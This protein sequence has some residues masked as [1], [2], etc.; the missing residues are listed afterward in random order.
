MKNLLVF[1]IFSVC[2]SFTYG[3]TVQ[4]ERKV[5]QLIT[6]Q[7]FYLNGGAKATL[8]VGGTSRQSFNIVLPLNTVEWYFSISTSKN[9]GGS[10]AIGLLAQLTRLYDPTG[11]L[12]I[13]TNSILIPSGDGVCNIYLM[14]KV[15]SDKFM[16][17]ADL[18]G[19][20]LEIRES[21]SRNNFQDGT[22]QIKDILA[23]SWYLGFKNP[24]TT[25]GISITVEVVAIVEE[26]KKVE[27]TETE[28]T[29]STYASLGWNSFVKGEY[30]KSFELCNQAVKLNPNLG[31]AHNNIGLIYL[32]KGN[33]ISAIES[34]SKAINLF[35]KS[36]KPER[37]L[38]SAIQTL[39]AVMT[40]HGPLEG[41]ND[42]LE[43]LQKQM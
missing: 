9:E 7:K 42:I 18:W 40:K 15:N 26:I 21:G 30:D 16:N 10:K 39:K 19:D 34:Y 4:K 31:W 1:F 24:S 32:I 33:Y 12:A 17:K 27:K 43:M 35:K 22:V 23:G 41:A 36:D 20:R 11:M 2:I 13:A 38:N 8:S 37:M 6:P 14:D 3:Q 25:Q 5:I 28:N 29:A